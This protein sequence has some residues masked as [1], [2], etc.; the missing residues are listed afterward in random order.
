MGGVEEA[1]Q[2]VHVAIKLLDHWYELPD[3]NF[4]GLLQPI[5]SLEVLSLDGPGSFHIPVQ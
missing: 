2:M 1:G 3:Q 4:I 5:A